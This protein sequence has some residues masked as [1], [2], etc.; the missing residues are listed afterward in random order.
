MPLNKVDYYAPDASWEWQPLPGMR[1]A[2]SGWHHLSFF[3]TATPEKDI[4]KPPPIPNNKGLKL[5]TVVE[6]ML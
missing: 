1:G 2:A 3:L 4:L 6:I 5:A